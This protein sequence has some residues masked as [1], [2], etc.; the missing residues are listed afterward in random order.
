MDQD[1]KKSLG[2]LEDVPKHSCKGI[3]KICL[4]SPNPERLVALT[5]AIIDTARRTVVFRAGNLVVEAL[6]TPPG[7][8]G[9]NFER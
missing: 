9:S 8:F 5:L 4:E 3:I 7:W 1:H 6:V 2:R